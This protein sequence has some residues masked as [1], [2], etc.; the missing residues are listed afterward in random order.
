MEVPDIRTGTHTALAIL[1]YCGFRLS[2]DYDDE[3]R[4]A[5][6]EQVSVKRLRRLARVNANAII[7]QLEFER[8]INLMCYVGGPRDGK[9]HNL[10][11]VKGERVVCWVCR[12]K[13]AIYESLEYMGRLK[14]VGYASSE[15]KA[16][17]GIVI[18]AK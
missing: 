2:L 8:K 1:R 3:L 11:K 15:A 17:R 5:Y 14:F 4:I 10:C 9:S 7:K 18:P 16:K 12:G 6:P 13:W